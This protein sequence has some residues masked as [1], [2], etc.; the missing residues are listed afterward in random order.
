M[1]NT[2]SVFKIILKRFE[3]FIYIY[4]YLHNYSQGM[5]LMPAF[6]MQ[7]ARYNSKLFLS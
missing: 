2:I 5:I 7:L 4:I 6:A 1:L 3:I